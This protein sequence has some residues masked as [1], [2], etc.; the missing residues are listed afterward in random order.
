M[1]FLGNALKLTDY[2]FA[3]SIISLFLLDA[4]QRIDWKHTDPTN[5]IPLIALISIVGT[6]L[7]IIDPFGNIL[8][9]FIRHLG[10]NL[11][12]FK[13]QEILAGLGYLN[14]STISLKGHASYVLKP[15]KY[16]GH[17]IAKALS[18]NWMAYEV[19]K[20]VSTIYFVIILGVILYSLNSPYY[21][22]T[23]LKILNNTNQ[24]NNISN[25]TT[26]A[27]SSHYDLQTVNNTNQA[28]TNL[29]RYHYI[30][31]GAI[32]IALVLT[33][34]VTI[35]SIRRSFKRNQ[36]ILIYFVSHNLNLIE[37]RNSMRHKVPKEKFQE[38]FDENFEVKFFDD[39]RIKE[40]EA[41]V[42]KQVSEDRSNV[43][44]YLDNKDWGMAEYFATS[45]VDTIL[46]GLGLFRKE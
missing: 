7:S 32:L 19:D 45:I 22:Q 24:T 14:Y 30:V 40:R 29:S 9:F 11:A 35:L 41:M 20:T 4:N 6:T 8:R 39:K 17:L 5:F 1:N 31:L 27:S 25:N 37:I 43:K 23:A 18:T 34:G 10:S 21:L 28:N 15:T 13:E 26:N 44:N 2:P 12:F 46:E 36:V 38:Q 16:Y 3:Y 33:L 42:V